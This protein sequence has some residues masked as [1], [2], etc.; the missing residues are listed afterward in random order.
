MPASDDSHA[1]QFDFWLGDWDVFWGDGLKGTN[2]V[3][4]ILGGSVI[5]E[6]FDGRPGMDFQGASLSVYSPQLGCW[7]QTWADSQGGYWAFT[8]GF[9]DGRMT[10]MTLSTDDVRDGRPVKLRM[11]F[12][13]IAPDSL[14]WNWERSDDGGLAWSLQWQ[15]H[16]ARRAQASPPAA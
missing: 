15:L 5:R 3:E 16:Y 12:F 14:D 7:R 2:H 6:S 8:G 11:V 4:A 1:R 9:A 10:L 13:N